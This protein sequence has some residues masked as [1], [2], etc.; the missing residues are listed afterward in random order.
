M[1][2]VK[3]LHIENNV[4][5]VERNLKIPREVKVIQSCPTL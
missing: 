5:N 4:N 1:K 2:D 3:D